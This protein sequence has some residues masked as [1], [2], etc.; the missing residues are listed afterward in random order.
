MPEV[1][2]EHYHIAARVVRQ[3]PKGMKLDM[4]AYDALGFGVRNRRVAMDMAALY[5]MDASSSLQTPITTPTIPG[6]IQFLQNWLPGQVHVMTAARKA[7]DLMGISTIGN[8]E[9]EQ[10]VQEL[11]ENVAYAKPYSDNGNVPLADYD[12]NFVSRT[13]VRMEMGMRVGNLEEARVARVR[14]N[15]GESKRQSCGLSLEIARNL[16]GFNGYNSGNDQTYGFLNE[17]GLLGY[18]TVANGA[19]GSPLWSK[20][21]YL[22]ILAD[23]RQAI[24]QLRTQSKDTIDPEKVDLTMGIATNAVDFLSVT[25]DFGNSVRDWMKETYPRIRVV[26]APQLNTANGGAGVFYLYADGV[27]DL[28]TDDGRTWIQVVPAKFLV[29]GV[30]K[31]A[32][33]YEEDYTNATA[34]AMCKRPFAVTRW[35]GIS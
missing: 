33:G 3:V 30:Q 28:S 22:E 11:L 26:S 16:I 21:T 35:S 31:L 7:D 5:A 34:G 23:I 6:L 4:A 25:S 2:Q 24:V 12:L 27:S 32:K 15:A 20:K 29:T 17:P 10:I 9:D 1:S 18:T 8:W 13:V 14:L 19:A